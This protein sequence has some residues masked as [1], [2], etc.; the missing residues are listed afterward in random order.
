MDFWRFFPGHTGLDP[1]GSNHHKQVTSQIDR[2]V[3]VLTLMCAY[4]K[5]H[6]IYHVAAF[7]AEV[8]NPISQYNLKVSNFQ[9]WTLITM[10]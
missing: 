5:A 7:S 3:A 10:R 6:S 2:I 8:H 4:L 9:R 1:R